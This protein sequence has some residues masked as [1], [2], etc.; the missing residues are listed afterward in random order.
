ML[1]LLIFHGREIVAKW[2][3]YFF[4]SIRARHYLADEAFGYLKRV[5]VTPA[6]YLRLALE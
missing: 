3:I 6:V 2:K 1:F 4:Q 5:T